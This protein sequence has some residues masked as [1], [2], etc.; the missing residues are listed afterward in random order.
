M[1][2]WR[3]D[4][5]DLNSA[6][7][8]YL[9]LRSAIREQIRTKAAHEALPSEQ[10]FETAAGVSRT[11]VRQA[12][13]DLVHEG[14]I[15]RR[16]GKGSFVAPPKVTE[17]QVQRL[18]SFTNA[19]AWL[20]HHPSTDVLCQR[21]EDA[22]AA[23]AE[24]LTISEGAPIVHLKRLRSLTGEPLMVTETWV[25]AELC[26][27]LEGADLGR[28]SLYEVF[29]TDH[30]H[31]IASGTRTLEA[32]A[33]PREVASALRVRSGSPT[34]RIEILSRIDTGRVLEFS[35]A[36]HRGDRT[37]FEI[38]VGNNAHWEFV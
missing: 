10:Q 34:M 35:I 24:K 3:F 22:P 2:S 16:K 4:E 21:V 19:M 33:A 37:R 31:A 1:T 18:T 38:E 17:P 23:V 15:Y 5:V 20:G 14:L 9:Q 30:G 7:P 25:P 29:R 27:G 26:S 8:Y 12:L 36:F 11:V 28:R 32:V 6:V 13:L